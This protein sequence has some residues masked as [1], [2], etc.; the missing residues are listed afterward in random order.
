MTIRCRTRFLLGKIRWWMDLWGSLPRKFLCKFSV[1]K[2]EPILSCSSWNA[3]SLI[4]NGTVSFFFFGSDAKL[5]VDSIKGASNVSWKCKSDLADFVMMVAKK[6][7]RAKAG[8]SGP[9]IISKRAKDQVRVL[10]LMQEPD[11]YGVIY[12]SISGS[13]F[14]AYKS[15]TTAISGTLTRMCGL[16]QHE[17]PLSF[18]QIKRPFRLVLP[19][20][21][22]KVRSRWT[23]SIKRQ[24]IGK[25]TGACREALY[26]SKFQCTAHL[27]RCEPARF[28]RTE[29][30]NS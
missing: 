11:T 26:T 13:A 23:R 20:V 18:G 10:D 19:R 28:L 14:P 9:D 29:F 2:K 25:L 12:G 3:A 27:W 24:G 17:I 6:L 15:Y 1:G 4:S 5:I 8:R 16:H 30:N 22:V 7:H 21:T